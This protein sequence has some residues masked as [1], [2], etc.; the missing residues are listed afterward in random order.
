MKLHI[1]GIIENMAGFV[2]P[3]CQEISDIWGT[4]GVS[5]KIAEEYGVPFLGRIPLDPIVGSSAEAGLCVFCN[6]PDS[7]GAI[8]MCNIVTNLCVEMALKK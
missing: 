2:C 8:A 5:E 3:C 4:V 7:L 6:S 1:L